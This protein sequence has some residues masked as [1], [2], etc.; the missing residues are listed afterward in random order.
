MADAK[1]MLTPLAMKLLKFDV[2]STNIFRNIVYQKFGTLL[3]DE[4]TAGI[5]KYSKED[6]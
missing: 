5:I 1:N 2:D 4:Y 3:R 6:N